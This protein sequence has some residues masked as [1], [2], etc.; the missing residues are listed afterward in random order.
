MS[1]QFQ[2]LVVF[3]HLNTDYTIIVSAAA[4]EAGTMEK[5]AGGR[6]CSLFVRNV[7][8]RGIPQSLYALCRWTA[9]ER[10]TPE[11]LLRMV[12]EES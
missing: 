8:V 4:L 11:E 7:L 6:F 12:G 5:Y 9:T 1:R 2:P 3:V 10:T